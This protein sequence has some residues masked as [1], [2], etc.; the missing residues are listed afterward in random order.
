MDITEQQYEVKIERLL[1][2]YP[3]LKNAFNWEQHKNKTFKRKY[4]IIS[5]IRK[6]TEGR[7]D[8]YMENRAKKTGRKKKSKVKRNFYNIKSLKTKYVLPEWFYSMRNDVKMKWHGST[9][10][11][12]SKT[13]IFYIVEMYDNDEK[14][15]KIGIT[16]AS[17]K[18][19]YF[20][21]NTY[22]VRT[23][24]TSEIPRVILFDVETAMMSYLYKYKHNY[25]PKKAFAG[26]SECFKYDSLL[27]IKKKLNRI[28]KE[29][30][31]K[32]ESE[33]Y[34]VLQATC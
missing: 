14:F 29:I 8:A 27:G 20:G 34:R 4:E 23:I 5:S 7:E 30:K 26:K 1:L 24:R 18:Q 11:N 15:I 10:R 28:E 3:Y 17:V 33:R 21:F 31:K 9:K 13:G 32:E 2:E 19:R 6:D 16:L 22:D 12:K 25:Y